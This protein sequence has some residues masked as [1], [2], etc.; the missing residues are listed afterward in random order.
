MQGEYIH[1]LGSKLA[2]PV[3]SSLFAVS[4]LLNAR[5]Y[6]NAA[7]AF[8]PAWWVLDS[9]CWDVINS[10]KGAELQQALLLVNL[11]NMRDTIRQT[12]Y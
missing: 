10:L 11:A 9:A 5:K 1:Y 2:V 6:L 4:I 7:D 12:I 8:D 3:S